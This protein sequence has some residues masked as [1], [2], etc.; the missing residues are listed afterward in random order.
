[1]KKVR[2]NQNRLKKIG[3][4]KNYWKHASKIPLQTIIELLLNENR[5]TMLYSEY[6]TPALRQTL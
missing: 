6:R 5:R 4:G 2:K 1:M 3:E